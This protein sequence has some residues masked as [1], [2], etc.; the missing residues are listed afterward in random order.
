VLHPLERQ[1]V[2]A[3]DVEVA[4]RASGCESRDGH[5]L[6]QRE[7]IALHQDAILEGPGFR[8]V[9]VANQVVRTRRLRA[10]GLPLAAGWKS[11]SAPADQLRC[12]HLG[13]H[14]LGSHLDGTLERAI[15]TGRSVLVEARR[16][17]SADTPQQVKPGG[18]LLN[19]RTR[20]RRIGVGPCNQARQPVQGDVPEKSL[21]R[22][23]AGI[24]DQRRWGLIAHAQAGRPHPD[25]TITDGDM[26]SVRCVMKSRPGDRLE[27]SNDTVR[28]AALAGNV[29]TDVHDTSRAR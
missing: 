20:R 29:V 23:L 1:R 25:R 19:A 2:F 27:R 5:R 12:G 14:R 11:G 7:R 28:S 9:G 4:L 10:H 21:P 13:D 24:R 15:A 16:I 3:A 18:W 6:D 26:R 8:F 17:D 22:M